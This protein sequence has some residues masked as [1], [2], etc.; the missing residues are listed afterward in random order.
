[1]GMEMDMGMEMEMGMEMGMAM[2]IEAALGRGPWRE[3]ALGIGVA[4]D[5]ACVPFTVI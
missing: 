4:W 3:M 1:M 2:E 5:A